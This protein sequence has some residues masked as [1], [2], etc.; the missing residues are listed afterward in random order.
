M[1]SFTKLCKFIP[2]TKHRSG[3][4]KRVKLVHLVLMDEQVGEGGSEEVSTLGSI[5]AVTIK[6]NI[7]RT[8]FGLVKKQTCIS[9]R[10]P[11]SKSTHP[12]KKESVLKLQKNYF[13]F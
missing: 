8:M 7:N 9:K 1:W 4:N 6:Q 10:S 5:Y 13:T 11:R 12:H 2:G 3:K